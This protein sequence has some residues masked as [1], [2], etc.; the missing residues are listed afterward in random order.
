MQVKPLKKERKIHGFT[1]GAGAVRA[2]PLCCFL[3]LWPCQTLT[4]EA[5]HVLGVPGVVWNGEVA[6]TNGH[7]ALPKGQ[8]EVAQLVQ[9]TAQG[10][11]RENRARI[12]QTEPSR[13]QHS[14][15]SMAGSRGVLLMSG[16]H[17]RPVRDLR[18]AQLQGKRN[19][20]R[21]LPH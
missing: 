12:Q 13:A 19:T 8:G 21:G 3:D 16:L 10:L 11:Q 20:C 4:D 14:S 1:V 6:I 7:L 17:Q 9:Q 18:Q 15:E 5:V 2:N